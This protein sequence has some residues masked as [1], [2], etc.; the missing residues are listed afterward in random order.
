MNKKEISIIKKKALEDKVPIIM[1][2]TLEV[3]AKIL[4]EIKPKK[5]LEI[6][7]AVGYSAI[8][9]SEYLQENGKIDTIERDTERVKEAREN[10]KKAEVE[11]KINIYEGDAVEIL[12]TLND[13]YDVVFIDAAKG[14]YPFFLNQALRMIKPGGVIFADNI[15]YKGYVMSD[16]NKHKQRTAV[17][18]LREYIAEITNNEKLETEILEVGDGLAISKTKR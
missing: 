12:P 9:F 5:I 6:G 3:I 17:R 18:N 11:E 8:C 13:E 2:D 14:K 1:D 4:D 7:T 16:Y 10:I 15:L